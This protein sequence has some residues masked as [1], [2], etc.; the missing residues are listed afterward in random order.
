M[1]RCKQCR[2]EIPPAAKCTD[3]ISKKGYCSGA[4][5]YQQEAGKPKPVKQP[6]KP[7]TAKKKPKSIARLRNDVAE[8]VQRLVRLKAADSNGMVKCW[9]CPTVKHWKEM[10]GGH[11]IE[12][13]KTATKMLEENIHP[14]CPSCNQWGMKKSSTVLLY[15]REMVAWYGE[16]FVSWLENESKKTIR[17]TR[18][19]LQ[20]L[21][22]DY[23]KQVKHF[24]E[25]VK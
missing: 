16:E 19:E 15:R 2:I 6:K 18:Q 8:L 3:F 12:R 13:G 10:Q 9:T 25:I 5:V 1:R 23:T 14:Q 20:L 21:L 11:F 7:A 4:C 17:H 24:E 22:A